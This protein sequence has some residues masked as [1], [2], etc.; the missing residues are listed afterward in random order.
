M[1]YGAVMTTTECKSDLKFSQQTSKFHIAGLLG[2]ESTSHLWFPPQSANKAE[3]IC[4]SW[5]HHIYLHYITCTDD[6]LLSIGRPQ[7]LSKHA[8]EICPHEQDHHYFRSWLV[9]CVA[10]MM[11]YCWL[12]CNHNFRLHF[13]KHEKEIP[14]QFFIHHKVLPYANP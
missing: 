9:A 1:T 12:A 3:N 10:P 13:S 4:V 14:R 6:G 7:I 5:L 8:R 2:G 11:T